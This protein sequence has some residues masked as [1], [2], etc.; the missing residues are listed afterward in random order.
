MEP[1]TL[2][3]DNT[4]SL[5]PE[6]PGGHIP[7]EAGVWILLFVGAL[8]F[9]V[10]S[11]PK[12]V[13]AALLVLIGVRLVNLGEA[14]HLREHGELPLYLITVGGVVFVNLLAGVAI[15]F[16]CAL[17]R[18]VWS[19]GKVQI[20]VQGERVTISGALTFLAVPRLTECLRELTPGQ[21]V[22]IELHVE[23]MDHAG[24][25][26]LESWREGYEA[27]GGQVEIARPEHLAAAFPGV[28]QPSPA[29]EPEPALVGAG[30]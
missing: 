5:R 2:S 25:A 13:L 15:G 14:K 11:I 6:P 19:L 18:L 23:S 9:V 10:E 30:H 20:E 3:P 1:A 24:W 29:P 12:T 28:A 21:R 26:A 16:A 22:V 7:G 17:L 8:P 27:S 4:G